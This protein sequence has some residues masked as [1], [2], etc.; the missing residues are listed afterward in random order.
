[1]EEIKW[2]LGPE[3]GDSHPP[4]ALSGMDAGPADFETLYRRYASCVN[5]RILAIVGNP[6]EAE[7]LS[8]D[9][10]LHVHGELIRGRVPRNVGPWLQRL[11]VHTAKRHVAQKAAHPEVPLGAMPFAKRADPRPWANL[12]AAL[13]PGWAP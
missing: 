9:V 2:V 1:M 3:D 5:R 12:D 6:I 7:E 10:F 13:E 8:Q 11:A 4:L